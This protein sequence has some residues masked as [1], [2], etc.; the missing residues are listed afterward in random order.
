M[1]FH[2]FCSILLHSHWQG[3]N[4]TVLVRGPTVYC[5]GYIFASEAYIKQEIWANAHE[6][7]ENL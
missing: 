2:L 5:D 3:S 1:I 6:M 4:I 7:R